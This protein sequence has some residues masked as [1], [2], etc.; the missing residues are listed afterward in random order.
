MPENSS[1]APGNEIKG[2]GGAT[3]QRNQMGS[4]G[5]P[6]GGNFGV[7][8]Y[9][10]TNGALLSHGSHVPNDGVQLHDGER[11]GPPM[12]KNGKG[13]M[14]STAHSNHGPHH[15]HHVGKK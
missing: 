1:H 4:G 6:M 13:S 12:I 8:P 9:S 15:H 14:G 10:K 11:S 3:R 5:A 2:E 7:E